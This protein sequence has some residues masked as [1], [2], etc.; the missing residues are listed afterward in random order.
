M[1]E[2]DQMK[3][4]VGEA[5]VENVEDGM[6]VGLGSGST[7][8]W[9][10]KKLG[11]RV[12]EGLDVEGVPTSNTTAE[13]AREFGVPLTDFSKVQELDLTIDG[14]D[15]V[16][17]QLHLIKGGGGALFREKVVAAAAKELVI[18][19]DGSKLVSQLGKFALPVEVLPFGWEVTAK[20]IAALG[21][22]PQLRTAG[23]ETYVTD[24]GNY[25]LDCPFGQIKDPAT[26]HNDLKDIVGVIETGLF[27]G[28]ADKI[29][30]GKQDKVEVISKA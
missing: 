24:N 9:M 6:K 3:K 30:V 2:A 17:E 28:M 19:V 21:C 10:V 1:N 27:I 23:E 14:A 5:A 8:Y 18:I 15:E 7:V 11:E 12:K 16:D 29:V 13:W 4:L 20:H 22:S 26:L 25:I